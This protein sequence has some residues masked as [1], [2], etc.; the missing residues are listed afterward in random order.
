M[1]KYRI[2]LI[3]KWT[4]ELMDASLIETRKRVLNRFQKEKDKSKFVG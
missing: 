4:Y 2:K 1:S 3:Q